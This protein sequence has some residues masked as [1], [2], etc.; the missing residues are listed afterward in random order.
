MAAQIRSV[1]RV[2][3]QIKK[4]IE[5]TCEQHGFSPLLMWMLIRQEADYQLL[6]L[7]EDDDVTFE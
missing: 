6:I 3:D 5:E 1:Y 4:D 2:L 7:Q